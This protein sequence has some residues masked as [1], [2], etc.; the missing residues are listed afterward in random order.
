[1]KSRVSYSKEHRERAAKRMYGLFTVDVVRPDGSR[2]TYQGLADGREGRYLERAALRVACGGMRPVSG[3]K[4]PSGTTRQHA[5]SPAQERRAEQR[6]E[7]TRFQRGRRR[8][9]SDALEAPR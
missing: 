8:G 1:M 5:P 3:S 4:R 6:T 7:G 9:P 2:V